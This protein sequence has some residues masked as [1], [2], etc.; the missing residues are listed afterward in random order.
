MVLSALGFALLG[1]CVKA[2]SLRGIPVFEILA[3]RALVS[4]V[5]SYVDIKRKRISPWGYNKP[6][7]VARG[8]VGTFSL[9]CV[10]YA[11]KLLPLAVATILQYLYPLFSVILGAVFLKEAIQRQ[12]LFCIGLS[13][14]GLALISRPEILSDGLGASDVGSLPML[15]VVAA[16]LGALGTSVAYVLVRKLSS[17]EDP[18]VIIFY[19]PFIALPVSLL[20]L[21]DNVVVPT[22]TTWILLLFVGIFTQF[23]QY[24]LTKAVQMEHVGKVTAYSYVQII[25]ATIFG[26]IFFRE[27]PALSTLFGGVFIVGGAFVNMFGGRK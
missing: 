26:F 10:F 7:L 3:F 22:G 17:T 13:L 14:A 6:L 5:L 24:C 2:S 27:Q 23:A 25:F 4:T 16:V 18:S 11:I 19:F 15:G 21:G 9:I 1:V 8:A 20:F 12:T